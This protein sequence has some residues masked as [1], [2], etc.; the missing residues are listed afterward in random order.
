MS[1]KQ[2]IKHRNKIIAIVITVVIL[3]TI[4]VFIFMR[5]SDDSDDSD[6]SETNTIPTDSLIYNFDMT[7]DGSVNIKMI[8][9]YTPKPLT[10][11]GTSLYPNNDNIV[12]HVNTICGPSEFC[13]AFVLNYEN[14]LN[15]EDCFQNNGILNN[16]C[17]YSYL[18]EN[19][20]YISPDYLKSGSLMD[21]FDTM[22]KNL[23]TKLS[24]SVNTD[25]N[26]IEDND[27]YTMMNNFSKHS[28]I[29]FNLKKGDSNDKC[30]LVYAYNETTGD[31]N[32]FRKIP[33]GDWYN[34]NNLEKY[35]VGGC[36]GG[37]PSPAQFLSNNFDDSFV[38][39]KINLTDSE[40]SS[41]NPIY[42]FSYIIQQFLLSPYI[43]FCNKTLEKYKGV[44]NLSDRLLNNLS[45]RPLKESKQQFFCD[46]YTLGDMLQFGEVK[47][48][49][50]DIVDIP[51]NHGETTIAQ[52]L[53]IPLS[54]PLHINELK[55]LKII[56]NHMSEEE[57]NNVFFVLKHLYECDFFQTIETRIKANLLYIRDAI[58]RERRNEPSIE[59]RS[60][61][62]M[63]NLILDDLK[64]CFDNLKD[65]NPDAIYNFF[66]SIG[67]FV[68]R[69]QEKAQ[70]LT[71]IEINQSEDRVETQF[72]QEVFFTKEEVQQTNKPKN[73]WENDIDYVYDTNMPGQFVSKNANMVGQST[74]RIKEQTFMNRSPSR[75]VVPNEGYH[76]PNE[77]NFITNYLSPEQI[78][79]LENLLSTPA[80]NL[81]SPPAYDS[82]NNDMVNIF[83]Y[84]YNKL[85]LDD[86]ITV[87]E[88]DFMN[89]A[90]RTVYECSFKK[91]IEELNASIFSN[92]SLYDEESYENAIQNLGTR[93]FEIIVTNFTD[94]TNFT[95][96]DELKIL[97]VISK[98]FMMDYKNIYKVIPSY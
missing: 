47:V 80:E 70:N 83:T 4:I 2:T 77:F 23:F 90:I 37:S 41:L 17:E 45:T 10:F 89:D 26:S 11:G 78:Y 91:I 50:T 6:D 42:I 95:F 86:I 63:Q 18:N 67:H 71:Q 38:Y 29:K 62:I 57:F 49:F 92:T 19:G 40:E 96:V 8:E 74:N 54:L 72:Q 69:I 82:S 46:I 84:A 61:S 52:Y 53:L 94:C 65:T 31:F 93:F 73:H 98:I 55:K 12:N 13:D 79:N 5:D 81:Q 48:L 68:I 25:C 15:I 60:P 75:D 7:D 51:E 76:S 34:S 20:T 43:S 88:R 28:N 66:R 59:Y 85:G 32:L 39:H 58:D 44:L 9:K 14:P 30:L 22:Y 97:K 64:T 3:V 27:H 35:N 87:D 24:E 1:G 33:G 56:Q 36:L 16:H 21:T